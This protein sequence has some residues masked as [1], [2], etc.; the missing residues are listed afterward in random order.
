MASDHLAHVTDARL[1]PM[2]ITVGISSTVSLSTCG[3]S[4]NA[5][6]GTP[7]SVQ[8]RQETPSVRKRMRHL[9]GLPA[10]LLK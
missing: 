7:R 8:T 5:F 10:K 2:V 3:Q 1:L 6:L 4:A 9:K